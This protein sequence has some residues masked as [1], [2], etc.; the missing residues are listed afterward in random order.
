MQFTDEWL[1]NTIE[2]LLP[3]GTI[4][5]LR[6]E[7]ASA[8]VSL[9]ETLA[10]RRLIPNSDVLTAIG[11][12][13]RIPVADLSRIDPRLAQV[14]PEAVARRFN[15]VPVGQTDSYLEVATA[16]PFD[17]DAEKM[18][19]FATGRE[20]R[21]LVASPSAIRARIDELYRNEDVVNRLLEGIG[22]DFE[23]KELED[24][25]DYA[26]ASAEEASQ[27]PIIRLVD[28]MLADGVT[29]RASDIHVEPVDGGVVVRYRID[30]VL[31]QV[32]KI[33]RN[34]GLPLISRIKIMSGLDIADRLRPQDGRARVSVNGEA[35]DLR[36][37]TLPASLG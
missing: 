14:V 32:M 21:M 33:P 36:V 9:W 17:I 35:V 3:E 15:V 13:F 27:R 16:N 10:Q 8:P 37:S 26:A 4:A 1:V 18:L 28:V 20:V 11:S 25:D 7:Q 29:S 12:R 31:R 19:A 23:V 24:E 5:R 22:G 2:P 30:G 6:A 34:A